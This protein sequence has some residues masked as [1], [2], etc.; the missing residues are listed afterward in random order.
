EGVVHHVLARPL[1]GAELATSEVGVAAVAIEPQANVRV[2]GRLLVEA[3]GRSD[4]GPDAAACELIARFR[5]VAAERKH[6][7]ASVG[8]TRGIVRAT[9]RRIRSARV[10]RRVL[11][12]AS[13]AAAVEA[14]EVAVVALLV[15]VLMMVAASACVRLP[16]GR[17]SAP[18]AVRHAAAGRRASRG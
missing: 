12:R 4:A 1:G 13:G 15:A 9:V 14:D 7:T 2:D 5:V 16:A 10:A 3:P 18:R 8:A 11:E 6:R 17:R